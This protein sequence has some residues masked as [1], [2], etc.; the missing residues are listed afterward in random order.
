MIKPAMK[1]LLTTALLLG[2]VSITRADTFSI[3]SS[4]TSGSTQFGD[5]KTFTGNGT[6]TYDG[7]SFS[8]IVFSLNETSPASSNIWTATST[9]GE[10]SGAGKQLIIGDGTSDCSGVDCV[11]ITFGS[12]IT[13]GSALSLSGL[14]GFEFKENYIFASATLT[15][16]T[17]STPEPASIVMLLTMLGVVGYVVSKKR[18][19]A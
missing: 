19:L 7:T 5:L 12:V 16:T 11:G 4:W 14:S 13:T 9:D 18:R 3:V 2:S 15:D 17:Y 6:F 10:L 1:L 8:N